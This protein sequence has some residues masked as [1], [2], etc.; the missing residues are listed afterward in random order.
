MNYVTL[1]GRL[2]ATPEL[3]TTKQSGLSV[4]T[5]TIAVARRFQ[6]KDGDKV[7]DFI[8]CVA[9]RNTAEFICK[10]FE[11]GDPIAIAGEIQT[12]KYEDNDG[13]KRTAFEVMANQAYFCGKKSNDSN[14]NSENNAGRDNYADG[15]DGFMPMPAD[16]ELPF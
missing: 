4:T 16:D 15:F 9:W 11:K 1:M 14:D 2:T 7:T 10:Y 13:N 8:N 12:R 6:P 5:F 3:K